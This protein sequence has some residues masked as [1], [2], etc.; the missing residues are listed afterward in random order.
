MKASEIISKIEKWTPEGLVD[1]WDNTGLQIGSPDQKINGILISMDITD[2]VVKKAIEQDMNMI[3]T[4]HPFIFKPMDRFVFNGYRGNIIRSVIMNE[5]VI[6]NAHTNLD[7]AEGGINDRLAQ[8]FG[9]REPKV[10]SYSKSEEL[11]KVAVYVPKTHEKNILD[12]LSASGAGHMG[13]Y[14]D[15]SF[16][17]DGTGRFRPLEGSNPYLGITDVLESVT[18][19]RIET[20]V[21]REYLQNTLDLIQKEHPYEEV[22]LDVYPLLNKGKTYGY[23]RVGE[24][25]GTTL[26]ELANMTK[27][28]L[29]LDSLRVYGSCESKIEKIAVCGGTGADFIREAA[30]KDAKVY[31]TGD[32]KYHDA[33]LAYEEG[34]VLIDGTHYGTERI[35]LPVIEEKLIE[36]TEGK[37]KIEVYEDSSFNF[38]CY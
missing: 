37:I 10:L 25:E 7:L 5:I 19:S 35:I 24:I 32:I 21:N 16:S 8:L 34:I 2:S 28:V 4:H 14:S 11:V 31:I 36:Y 17:V 27:K 18:E 3:I 13:E 22:A 6:Y 38:E 23:G 20:I 15:C 29:Q 9:M 12:A 30:Q 1:S 26:N 33:Q